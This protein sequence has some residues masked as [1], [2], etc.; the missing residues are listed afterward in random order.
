MTDTDNVISP[1]G[2]TRADRHTALSFQVQSEKFKPPF[3]VAFFFFFPFPHPF[4]P[5]IKV[6]ALFLSLSLWALS[7]ASCMSHLNNRSG[8]W[9]FHRVLKKTSGRFFFLSKKKQLIKGKHS[10]PLGERIQAPGFLCWSQ[11]TY[12]PIN[13][14]RTSSLQAFFLFFISSTFQLLT[15]DHCR[16]PKFMS[17]VH[18]NDRRRRQTKERQTDRKR[19]KISKLPLLQLFFFSHTLLSGNLI[20]TRSPQSHLATYAA[21]KWG[22]VFSIASCSEREW[23]RGRERA[24][25]PWRINDIILYAPLDSQ[26]ARILPTSD[27]E[28]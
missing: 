24:R 3:R 16:Y 23:E 6:K 1:E 15:N 21:C 28:G 2:R 22:S 8:R 18:H 20:C 5:R 10:W 25:L 7:S 4:L 14:C 26:T 27:I 17:R 13:P 9:V 12:A 11:M 19:K